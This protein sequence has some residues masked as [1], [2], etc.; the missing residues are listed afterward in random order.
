MLPQVQLLQTRHHY[1]NNDSS[2]NGSLC[3]K[4]IPYTIK[5]KNIDNRFDLPFGLPLIT[6][7]SHPIFSSIPWLVG[8]LYNR[9]DFQN[10][11]ALIY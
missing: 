1:I 5:V 2:H 4:L 7:F 10:S 9:L 3:A 6:L 11:L 8:Q